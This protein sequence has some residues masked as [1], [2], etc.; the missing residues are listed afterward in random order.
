MHRRRTATPCRGPRTGARPDH[1][2]CPT[3]DDARHRAGHG[4]RCRL[5]TDTKAQPKPVPP[6]TAVTAVNPGTGTGTS[7]LTLV[8]FPVCRLTPRPGPNRA[9]GQQRVPVGVP[10]ADR[11]HSKRTLPPSVSSLIDRDCAGS[12]RRRTAVAAGLTFPSPRASSAP[13]R[14][15]RRRDR[16]HVAQARDGHRG[17]GGH[18]AQGRADLPVRCPR[19][20]GAVAQQRVPG[21]GKTPPPAAMAV[22]VLIPVTSTGTPASVVVPSPSWCCRCSPSPTP[23]RPSAA[24]TR[25]RGGGDRGHPGEPAHL[26]RGAAVYP[27]AVGA[28]GVL[29][30]GVVAKG[31][32]AQPQAHTVLFDATRTR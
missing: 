29:R 27:R 17:W 6:P 10:G 20:D 5:G 3:R 19:L 13:T 25:W 28:A 14:R 7:L 9:V 31:A 21:P 22:A 18:V 32:I 15:G 2:R 8:P 23:C 16:D 12:G 24:R 4:H 1:F 30:N 11:R 26:D